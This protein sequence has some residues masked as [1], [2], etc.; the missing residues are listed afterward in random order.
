MVSF[1]NSGTGFGDPT[2]ARTIPWVPSGGAAYAITL[3]FSIDGAGVV[4]LDASTT[5]TEP[6]FQNMVAE[7]DN[8]SVGSVADP[9]LLNQSFTLTGT[10]AGG[11]GGL[12]ITENNGGGIGVQGENSNRV[13]GLNY[14]AGGTTS[15]P[16]TL[17]WTLSAPVGIILN[18]FSSFISTPA[19]CRGSRGLTLTGESRRST[20][21]GDDSFGVTELTFTVISRLD[22]LSSP[23][24]SM[25]SKIGCFS[26]FRNSIPDPL[27]LTMLCTRV[28]TSTGMGNGEACILFKRRPVVS[29]RKKCPPCSLP[30]GRSANAPTVRLL[31]EL[32]V[33]SC[34]WTYS[35]NSY[36]K[37]LLKSIDLPVIISRGLKSS[38]IVC[39]GENAFSQ[40][41]HA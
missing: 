4:S 17:T 35:P 11:V 2:D 18:S 10:R 29:E 8:A 24:L 7:W 31:I 36:L 3:D 20:C 16:E 25:L 22:G 21:V 34:V 9:A 12:T 39:E 23:R 33:A 5:A 37:C 19:I 6:L 26:L 41:T 28:M 30:V 1:A 40:N 13:D 38:P 27:F 14:G 32:S 15:T